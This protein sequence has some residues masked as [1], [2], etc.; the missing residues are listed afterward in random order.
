M[1]LERNLQIFDGVYYVPP[2][3]GSIALACVHNIRYPDVCE[4]CKVEIKADLPVE[5]R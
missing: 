5:G 4:E 2:G 3:A 1:A